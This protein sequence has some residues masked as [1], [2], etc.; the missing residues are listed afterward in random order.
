MST[1]EDAVRT[2]AVKLFDAIAAANKE[3]LV[4]TWPA[5]LDGLHKIA[6]SETDQPAPAAT[7]T[8]VATGVEPGTREYA[9]VEHVA[10]KAVDDVTVDKK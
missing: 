2:A 7:I 1:K 3:G 10:Q 9:K 6:I 5:T 8:V 4:V